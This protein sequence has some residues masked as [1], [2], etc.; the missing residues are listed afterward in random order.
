MKKSTAIVI[1]L[2]GLSIIGYGIWRMATDK[3]AA[4]FM[5]V[6]FGAVIT[7]GVGLYYSKKQKESK[8]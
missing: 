5:I 6:A 2:I 4:D 8:K 7:T 3:T 1:Q